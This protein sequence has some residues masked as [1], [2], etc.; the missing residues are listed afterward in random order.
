M[1]P[2]TLEERPKDPAVLAELEALTAR[3]RAGD[4]T[5]LAR[6]RRILDHH[7][8]IWRYAADTESI[9]FRG[10]TRLLANGDSVSCEDLRRRVKDLRTQL[11]GETP[12]P[13]ERLLCGQTATLALV[14]GQAQ[15][16]EAAPQGKT[17]GQRTR[18]RKRSESVLRRCLA[19]AKT[20]ATVRAVLPTAR[21][22][23]P[24]TGL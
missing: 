1:P 7:E 17:N 13:L 9:L 11:E 3:A 22:R 10:W 21:Q 12:T 6:M 5:V 4:V 15:I 2:E 8:D 16:Q 19:A 23:V 24:N 14:L 18:E 20:L